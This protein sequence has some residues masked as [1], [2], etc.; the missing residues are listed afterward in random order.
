VI[1]ACARNAPGGAALLRAAALLLAACGLL[2]A[3]D[4]APAEVGPRHFEKE[5]GFSFCPPKGWSIQAVPNAKYKYAVLIADGFT[6]FFNAT[7]EQFAGSLD[8]YVA[9]NLHSLHNI[10]PDCKELSQAP[11]ATTSGLVGTMRVV[12][13]TQHGKPLRQSWFF[14]DG[15]N[16]SKY[17]LK[18]AALAAD[19]ERRDAGFLAAAKSFR[20]EPSAAP[21]PPAKAP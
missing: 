7:D 20:V 9:A 3:A 16:G 14:I 18:G 21:A 19:G 6:P 1:V 2:H 11:F 15:G 13:A 4:P 17:F 5:G 10:Y 8:D 12:L